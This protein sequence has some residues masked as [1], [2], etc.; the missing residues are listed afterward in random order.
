MSIIC[1]SYCLL[2]AIFISD[3]GQFKACPKHKAQGH[4]V[5]RRKPPINE[6]SKEILFSFVCTLKKEFIA[7]IDIL[8]KES[9]QNE[10]NKKYQEELKLTS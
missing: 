6:E 10:D 9:I 1:C 3:C 7:R 8:I 5:K 2:D 4:Q